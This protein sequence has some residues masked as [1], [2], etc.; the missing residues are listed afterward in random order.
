MDGL[1]HDNCFKTFELFWQLVTQSLSSYTS[2]HPASPKAVEAALL[3]LSIKDVCA[4]FPLFNI[5]AFLRRL[6]S[7]H[8]AETC[9]SLSWWASINSLVALTVARR[10]SSTSFHKVSV[11]AWAFFDNAYAI[12]SSILQQPADILTAQSLLAMVM[13]TR[14]S[15]DLRTTMILLSNACRIIQITCLPT[16]HRTKMEDLDT[17]EAA[18]RVF[19]VAFILEAEIYSSCGIPLLLAK[20]HTEFDVPSESSLNGHEIV[21]REGEQASVSIFRHRAELAIIQSRVHKKLYSTK[22]LT[23]EG[24]R[25]LLKS[26]LQ[27]ELNEWLSKVPSVIRPGLDNIITQ[28]IED[29]TVLRLHFVYFNCASMVYWTAYR[30]SPNQVVVESAHS[31][32]QCNAA[33]RGTIS[34]LNCA[35]NSP[36]S[37]LWQVSRDWHFIDY[38]NILLGRYCSI[39]SQ[40]ALYCWSICWTTLR[41]KM[42][43]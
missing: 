28:P 12:F 9:D 7:Q 37:E 4:E 24:S 30:A 19:W 1:V 41:E 20:D 42:F 16:G 3:I 29:L 14:S 6:R 11:V 8:T 10:I 15:A 26:K 35:T 33:A 31:V 23:P 5:P 34:L 2:G 18:N 17:R 39:S 40:Q 38:S 32:R 21:A 25:L 27:C 22:S 13:F 43:A 36:T